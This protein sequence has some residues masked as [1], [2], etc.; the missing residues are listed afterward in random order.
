MAQP[1]LGMAHELSKIKIID[2]PD[3]I[4]QESSEDDVDSEG[5][6]QEEW[7]SLPSNLRKEVHHRTSKWRIKPGWTR[8]P[9]L[10]DPTSSST[11]Q[12]QDSSLNTVLG[13]GYPV[14]YPLH[15]DGALSFDVETMP[16]LSP[17]PV[18]A[19]AVGKNAWYSWLSPWLLNEGE[20]KDRM[21]HLI[22]FGSNSILD[23][24]SSKQV[25][26]R[27]LIGH[28]VSFDR[29]R[30]LDEYSL[31][32]SEIRF[33]DTMSLHVATRGISSPQRPAWV[34]HSKARALKK[35]EKY[36]KQEEIRED[37][38]RALRMV[39]GLENLDEQGVKIEESQEDKDEELLKE[40][41]L[42]LNA[43]GIGENDEVGNKNTNNITNSEGELDHENASTL[44]QD[45]TSSNSLADVAHLHCGISISKEERNIFV[46]ATDRSLI[47]DN[48]PSLLNYCARDSDI[49]LQVFQKVFPSFIE[50]CPNPTT[51]AGVLGL[52]SAI[53]TI[54]Q[55]WELYRERSEEKYESSRL[56]VSKSLVELAEGLKEEGM[57]GLSWKYLEWCNKR[58][59]ENL[60]EL[61]LEMEEKEK[62]GRP[63]RE[64][65]M[66]ASK[67]QTSVSNPI[68]A[69]EEEKSFEAPWWE[70]DPWASQLDWT[71]KRPKRLKI[72]ISNSSGDGSNQDSSTNI[73][74]LPLLPGYRRVP[75]WYR[76]ALKG[77]NGLSPRSNALAIILKLQYDGRLIKRDES[78]NWIATSSKAEDSVDLGGSPLRKAFLKSEAKKN[79]GILTSSSNSPSKAQEVLQAIIEGHEEAQIRQLLTECAEEVVESW[80]ESG[81]AEREDGLDWKVVEVKDE[82]IASNSVADSETSF[83]DSSKQEPDWWPKWYW[84]LFDPKTGN[85][86]LT[87]RTRISPILL[88]ISWRGHPLFHSREHGWVYRELRSSDQSSSKAKD[89][90]PLTF[91]NSA[92]VL[93]HFDTLNSL[94]APSYFKVPHPSGDKSN[95][96]SPFSKSFLSLLENEVLQSQQDD[97]G[98]EAAKNALEM[99]AQCSYWIGVRDRVAQQMVVWNG[100][101]GTEMG[102]D[103]DGE[104]G[105]PTMSTDE[106]SSNPEVT[107]DKK[108]LILPQVVSMGTVTRRAIEKTWLT[109]SNAKKNRVGSELKAMVK[110]P[111]GWSI[112]GADVDSEELW[113]C[114]VMGDAQFGFHGA[115]AVGWMTLEGTKSLGTDLHS[116]TASILGTSRNQAK[117]FNYSRIYGAGINHAKQLLMKADPNMS[118]EEAKKRAK[119]LYS[120]TKG[121]SSPQSEVFGNR[122]FWYGG[123]ESYVFNKLEEIAISN[124][125]KTPALDCGV[126][127]ALSRKYLP[128]KTW[129]DGRRSEDYMPSRINWVVQSSG[130]DYLHL[131]ITSMEHLCK[132]YNIQARFMLSV[133][134]EVRYL[135]KEEDTDRTALALQISNLWTRAMF[136][137]KLQID[138]LPQGCAFF[139]LVDTDKV[140]RKEVDDPCV[141]PSHPD[142]IPPG[143]ALDIE[144]TLKNTNNGSLHKDGRPMESSEVLPKPIQIISNQ[145]LDPTSSDFPPYSRSDQ[146]H[147]SVGDK[148]LYY[149]QA[150]AAGDSHEIRALERRA[151]EIEDQNHF[152]PS[153]EGE[154]F[155][156]KRSSSSS[157]ARKSYTQS[158]PIRRSQ[159]SPFSTQSRGF[160]SLISSIGVF[161]TGSRFSSTSVRS[162]PAKR[163]SSSSTTSNSKDSLPLPL[164]DLLSHLPAKPHFVRRTVHRF[165]FFTKSDHQI[166]IRWGLYRNLMR[167][168]NILR[169][170]FSHLQT[171]ESQKQ[172]DDMSVLKRWIKTKFQVYSKTT[173]KSVLLSRISKG[174]EILQIMNKAISNDEGSRAFLFHLVSKILDKRYRRRW[175][176]STDKFIESEKPVRIP[177]VS[178]AL[179][180]ASHS[181]P[182]LPRFKPTQPIEV[183]MTIF[184]RRIARMKRGVQ[185]A[186]L[187]E[188]KKDLV[189]EAQFENNLIS[190]KIKKGII[191]KA[192]TSFKG[193]VETWCE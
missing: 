96:G 73:Q 158:N 38:E 115:T 66:N 32:R 161:G 164:S 105:F 95:V 117:V 2:H 160:S 166:Q 72:P 120:K 109:A 89:S 69:D 168:C 106:Q 30:I 129:D 113:I 85:L 5:L 119:D 83:S 54:D 13:E 152:G 6:D 81:Y 144:Q 172:A 122:R 36:L 68:E 190:E 163:A 182:P 98:K 135:C 192:E 162:S 7:I 127:A 78:G 18:M 14:D 174:N 43:L 29:A 64:V 151:R 15:E 159:S 74:L 34:N 33:L 186:E 41:D 71:P 87:I 12:D 153:I 134:D 102:F 88:K 75:K 155:G 3:G 26:A 51:L 171:P 189:R 193:D 183:S 93:L 138:N 139:A 178:G 19:T 185:Q 179:L 111:A 82:R 28:N 47:L 131:L 50:S 130:V 121:M 169:N 76:E 146:Q 70:S 16:K 114:S 118:E 91:K 49:T 35:A 177:H 55:E 4:H 167:C 44:W 128:K 92:D 17:Y 176:N 150:Q 141:T 126:T 65:K 104:S 53:L 142:P 84:D 11:S 8:Y 23:S 63:V 173:Q 143:L 116:K 124:Q 61:R 62:K 60:G 46:E 27:L 107:D 147:R 145:I 20:G 10:R 59:E 132:A 136:S 90:K 170:E 39:L 48:L 1:W 157:S 21:D 42:D 154:N 165:P 86:D 22:P 37:T 25:P 58:K 24:D 125:P 123:T 67:K 180:A 188:T 137:H 100:E 191:K 156:R 79:E 94:P 148:G 40:L 187:M 108:G 45:V 57:K 9:I 99:N 184:R 181:N 56:D 140:L 110:A 175:E 31:D 149:L 133:H 101:A 52:G 112:V 77:K 80:E 103:R 97:K